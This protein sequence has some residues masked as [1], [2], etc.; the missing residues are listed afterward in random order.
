MQKNVFESPTSIFSCVNIGGWGK[1]LNTRIIINTRISAG[2][3]IQILKIIDNKL[4]TTGILHLLFDLAKIK[5][6]ENINFSDVQLK[7]L[8]FAS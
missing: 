3:S 2:N 6:L 4:K 5:S 8:I 1:C 7:L